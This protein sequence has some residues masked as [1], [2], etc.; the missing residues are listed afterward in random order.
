[1]VG[2]TLSHYKI[3]EPVGSGAM[4]DVFKAE[5]TRLHRFVAIKVMAKALAR[6]AV[7]NRRFMQE[8]R[9]ASALDHPN[10][11]IVHDIGETADGRL[12]LV[13]TYYDGETI[14]VKIRRGPL[15]ID[16]VSSI[17]RQIA[18]GLS[19]THE[20]GIVHRDVK[21]GNLLVTS[22]G[23]V[24]ILDFGLAKLRGDDLSETAP[25]AVLGT[26]RYMSP[27]Q[28]ACAAVDFRS[29]I[30]SFGVVMYEML[31]GQRP[32][33][34][35]HSSA[36][37]HSILY[38]EPTPVAERRAD[39]PEWL[40]D[41]VGR[42]L[43]KSVDTRLQ[44]CYEVVR[45][46]DGTARRM[47]VA[48]SRT[49][50]PSHQRRSIMVT[51]FVSLGGDRESEHFGYGLAD[52]IITKLS[53]LSALRVITRTAVDR[54]RQRERDRRRAARQLGVEYL[55][56]GAVRR[57]DTSLRV[58][59]NLSEAR[60]GSILWAE[61][62][63]GTLDDIFSI[64]DSISRRIVEALRVRFSGDEQARFAG[65][66]LTDVQ[67]YGYYLK[68]KQEFVRYAPGGLDRALRYIDAARSR[69]ADNVLLLAAAGHIYW[70][71]V[72]SGS[73]SD[74][75]YLAKARGCA[76]RILELDRESP[77]A[78]RLNGMVKLLEGDIREAIALLEIAATKDP[79]DTDTLSLLGP[80]YGY[81]GRPRFGA[82]YVSR[83][84]ELDPVTPMY[85]AMPGI[86]AIMAG[87]FE[88][89]LEPLSTSFR[90]DPGNPLVGLCYG[91]C[92][93]LNGETR[94]ANEMFDELQG[95]FAD[96][97]LA[98]VGQ[99]YKCAVN[100]KAQEVS[101]WMTPDVEST[102]EWDLYHSWNLAECFALL[103]DTDGA[104][105]W[106][107][108]ATERGLLNYPL[109]A[110]LDPMLERLRALVPFERMMANVRAQWEELSD[111]AFNRAGVEPLSPASSDTRA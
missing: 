107:A 80:C 21:P 87:S 67:A 28:V 23:E 25:G 58:S 105:R 63:N 27:E 97:F 11:C 96:T 54:L 43:S 52:E 46:L 81:V 82:P 14:R 45:V 15:P 93:A 101:R 66:P 2:Q 64:Q 100:G 110:H 92:L 33:D 85:Q 9:A 74:R 57:Q 40:A 86:L 31:T 1:M 8:A 10:V 16:Q 91:Q 90:L 77:H 12:F 61:Q 60:T 22:F 5:D 95:R 83:L 108:H 84:L 104:L 19:R 38:D 79:S 13:M 20:F 30:W 73:S 18:A 71:F 75:S 68:A 59:A 49:I 50:V 72:N 111:D 55:V 42:M 37:F 7:L 29:D 62:F 76:D 99:L 78:Y 34:G 32:F 48:E 4:G 98:R 39:T 65:S 102:A 103:G 17:A 106:L 6:D 89:A 109:L 56:E 36:V 88:D 51:P 94:K 70:Q 53:Q 24:K 3:L 44:S 41:L 35:E 26:V 47:P 69:V